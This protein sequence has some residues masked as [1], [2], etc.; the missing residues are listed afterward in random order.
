MGGVVYAGA[1][2]TSLP[3]STLGVAVL[4]AAGVAVYGGLAVLDRDIRQVVEQYSPV[5]IPV[6]RLG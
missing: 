3:D 5:P 1:T 6:P 2:T 4:V